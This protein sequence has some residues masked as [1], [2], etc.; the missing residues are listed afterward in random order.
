MTDSRWKFIAITLAIGFLLFQLYQMELNSDIGKF[1]FYHQDTV[2]MTNT[3][4]HDPCMTM[5]VNNSDA[6]NSISNNN[7]VVVSDRSENNSGSVIK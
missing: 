5:A 6:T 4:H 3:D 1:K 7:E 2:S